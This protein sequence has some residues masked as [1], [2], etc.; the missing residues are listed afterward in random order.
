[1]AEVLDPLDE[2]V[3]SQAFNQKVHQLY[4]CTEGFLAATCPQGTLHLN[5]DILVIQKDYI[6]QASGRFMPII[7]DFNRPTQPIIRYRLD[8]ILTERSTPCPCGSLLTAI[9]QIE[10]RCDDIFYLPDRT[11]SHLIP[12]FPDLIRRAIILTSDAIQEYAAVQTSETIQI[13]LKVPE[14]Q[15]LSLTSSLETTL[16][17]LLERSGCQVPPLHFSH[18]ETWTH[19]DKKLRRVRREVPL[20]SVDIPHH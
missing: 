4:Q 10:G 7:T 18:Y 6:D 1:M 16:K 2:R 5:E 11:R 8:D 15:W 14:T 12:I 17:A 13:Y 9:A 3:I 20:S 19:Y